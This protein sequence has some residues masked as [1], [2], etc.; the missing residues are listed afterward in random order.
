MF[1]FVDSLTSEAQKYY[2]ENAGPHTIITLFKQE[3]A[4]M[5]LATQ[6]L[7]SNPKY[8]WQDLYKHISDIQE[9]LSEG[10]RLDEDQSRL[11]DQLNLI[12]EVVNDVV[13]RKSAYKNPVEGVKAAINDAIVSAEA[14]AATTEAAKAP[15]AE[16][17]A[18]E[19]P[20]EIYIGKTDFG[21]NVI[22][23]DGH[24]YKEMKDAL[25]EIHNTD[26][27]L[28][29][30]YK[31]ERLNSFGQPIYSKDGKTFILKD[32]TFT[33]I[34]TIRFGENIIG[35][36]PT[37]T[38]PEYKL[39]LLRTKIGDTAGGD[40]LAQIKD[41]SERPPEFWMRKP[42]YDPRWLEPTSS[43]TSYKIKGTNSYVQYETD[44]DGSVKPGTLEFVTGE[45]EDQTSHSINNLQDIND[46]LDI[47]HL[48]IR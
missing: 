23:Q 34:K 1:K 43:P 20:A 36:T 13:N 32:G 8:E 37:Q 4:K 45:G 10:E 24:F 25:I 21:R 46:I 39:E 7:E 26:N 15:A 17:P 27:I 29:D 30:D 9:S 16:V 35:V 12:N 3:L 28:R 42:T 6:L 33:P 44:S 41:A 31:F 47:E 48:D 11:Y 22:Y 2:S 5:V 40:I 19:A 14:R 38:S 18:A